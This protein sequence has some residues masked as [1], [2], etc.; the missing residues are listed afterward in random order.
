MIGCGCSGCGVLLKAKGVF[1]A[2]SHVQEAVLVLLLLVQLP[3]RDAGLGQHLAHEQEDGLL[4]GQLDALPDDVHELGHRDV[5]G[6]QILP[7]VD[8]QDL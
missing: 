2:V 8:V 4:W 1:S 6:Q 3:H 7:L 5:R